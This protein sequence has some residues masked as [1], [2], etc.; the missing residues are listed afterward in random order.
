V[1]VEEAVETRPP[2]ELIEKMVV[3]AESPRITLKIVVV[4]T[5]RGLKVWRARA[6][7]W[8]E[9]AWMVRSE[10]TLA[11]VVPTATLSPM[12]VCWTKVPVSVQPP[13]LL[14]KAHE[15]L[16]DP[17]VCRKVDADWEDGQV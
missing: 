11:E 15:R 7:D 6:V 5:A 16:P 8:V 10:A 14:A 17:S 1:K 3:E 4:E 9:V 12:V 2:A 13:A